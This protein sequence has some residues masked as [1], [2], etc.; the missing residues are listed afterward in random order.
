MAGILDRKTRFIDTFLTQT[1]REQ[2]AR[3]ELRFNFATF[4]DYCT[5]YEKSAED[6]RVAEDAIERI[7][8]EAAN[9]PQDMIIPEF[10]PSGGLFF[11]AGDFDLVDGQLKI[12]SGS[13][14]ATILKGEALVQS[15][16]SMIS[17]SAESFAA[18]RPLR[19]E[20]AVTDSTGFEIT[21]NSGE[22]LL[23]SFLPISPSM[24]KEISLSNVESFWQDKKLTHVSNFKF[25]PPINKVSKK[26]LKVFPKLQQP[27][28]LTYGDLAQELGANDPSGETGVGPPIS[29]TFDPTSNDNNL[30]GQVFEVRS[31]GIDKLRMI[32]FGEFEDADPYSPGKH[33]FFIGK[34]FE[35]D[36]GESTFVNLFTVVFD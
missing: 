1:G 2:I 10:E 18:M 3:G 7:F 31:D 33:I 14:G 36:D 24:P 20:E 6:T 19:T 9:R 25:M 29:L 35:D 12:I 16:S 30:V 13:G 32:D 8:F 4:S 34:I 17:D 21:Q 11:P 28:P 23:T 15:A 5:F 26:E 27:A 22:F